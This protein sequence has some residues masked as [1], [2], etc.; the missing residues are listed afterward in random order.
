MRKN[1]GDL[2]IRRGTKRGTRRR[3]WR[4]IRR[5]KRTRRTRREEWSS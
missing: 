4:G 5:T 1:E 2:H 3:T